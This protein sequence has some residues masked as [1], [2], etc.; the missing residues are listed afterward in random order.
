MGLPIYTMDEVDQL[1]ARA[2]EDGLRAGLTSIRKFVQDDRVKQ[3]I[4]EVESTPREVKTG[5]FSITVAVARSIVAEL[6]LH[7]FIVHDD[8]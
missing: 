8:A 7:G 3:F 1:T 4:G 6:R 5:S 2:R